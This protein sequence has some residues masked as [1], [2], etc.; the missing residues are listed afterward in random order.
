M[1]GDRL[2]HYR[3]RKGLSLSELA[4]RAGIAKSYISSIERNIQTNPSIQFL[5]KV[6]KVLNVPVDTLLHESVDSDI[7]NLDDEWLDLVQEAMDSGISKNEFKDFL[8][9]NKWKKEQ[10]NN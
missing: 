10:D 4:E 9:Y 7:E 5:E 8:Q 1:I 3:T 2:K 6:S